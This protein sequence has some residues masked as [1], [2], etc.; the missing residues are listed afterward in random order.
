MKRGS[1]IKIYIQSINSHIIVFF[2]LLFVSGNLHAFGFSHFAAL[3]GPKWEH[4]TAAQLRVF[5]F[6]QL[7]TC[8]EELA[9]NGLFSSMH[10]YFA[11]LPSVV[12]CPIK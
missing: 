2:K 11:R 8:L 5:G 1:L 10:I 12:I 7:P 3:P 4:P 9:D 6:P